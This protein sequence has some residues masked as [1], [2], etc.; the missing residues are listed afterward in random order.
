MAATAHHVELDYKWTDYQAHVRNELEHGDHDL[1]VLRVGYGGGKSRCGAQWIHRGAMTDSAGRSES[2]VMAQDYE[3]GKATTYSVF[4]KTLPGVDTNPFKNGDPENSPLVATYN[5]NDKMLRYATGHVTWIG[6]ADKWSRFAGGE[7]CRIWCD[8]VAHYPPKTSLYDLHEMLV[9]RQRTDVGPNSTLWTSTG[10]GFNEYYDI[11]ERQVQPDGDGGEE[12]LPWADRLHVVVASTEN[13]I[14]LPEDSLAKIRRQFEGTPR[15]EQGLHGGFAA[16]E[17]LV[18]DQF[19]RQNH[20]HP[21]KAI[22]LQPDWRIYGYDYGWKDPRVVIEFAKTPAEQYVAW[23]CYYETGNSVEDAI[24]W[25]RTN[26]KPVGPIYSDHDPEHI[27]KFRQAGFPAEAAT[28]DLDEG[29]TEV[30]EVLKIDPDVGPGL[31]VV[32][33]L[34][35]LIQEF[36]SYKEDD[37]GTSRVDD[38]CLDVTRYAI[39]GD[40]YTEDDGIGGSGTW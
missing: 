28:K 6:G 7:Y 13:N 9:T 4:F 10:N 35:E 2:L 29:I 37:V 20:V 27:E 26:D 5:K 25:L 3:K 11:T 30:Q 14:L 18:Y 12:E 22:T 31:L 34:I 40:R 15:E 39:M 36:Q 32:D 21:R 19:S 33:E 8:E 38:H 16:A 23:D 17:G 1:V 24:R